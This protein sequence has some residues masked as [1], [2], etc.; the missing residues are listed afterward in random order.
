MRFKKIMLAGIILLAIM[1]IGAVGAA[2]DSDALAV[3]EDAGNGVDAPAIDEDVICDGDD[4]T[5]DVDDDDS[6]IGDEDP[7]MSV[8]FPDKVVS[9][10]KFAINVTF[11][12][13]MDDEQYSDFGFDG[14]VELFI[15]GEYEDTFSP[16]AIYNNDSTR[17][18]GFRTVVEGAVSDVGSYLFTVSFSGDETY[19]NAS[20]SKAYEITDYVIKPYIENAYY[21]E[22]TSIDFT[23]PSTYAGNI[24]VTING[25]NRTLTGDDGYSFTVDDLA[26]GVNDFGYRYADSSGNPVNVMDVINIEGKINVPNEDSCKIDSVI[27]LKMPGDANGNLSVLINVAESDEEIA[28]EAINNGYV[29]IPISRFISTLGESQEYTFRYSGDGKYSIPVEVGILSLVPNVEYPTFIVVGDGKDYYVTVTVPADNGGTVE[30]YMEPYSD[31]DDDDYDDDD[32]DDYEDD[33]DDEGDDSDVDYSNYELV[34]SAHTQNGAAKIKIPEISQFTSFLISYS[35]DDGKYNYTID[36]DIDAL[37]ADD[38]M[39]VNVDETSYIIGDMVYMDYQA[40]DFFNGTV[41]IYLDGKILNATTLIFDDGEHNLQFNTTELGCGIHTLKFVTVGNINSS[42][43]V[44]FE[45]SQCIIEF[46]GEEGRIDFSDAYYAVTV[47][48]AEGSNGTLRVTVNGKQHD[49]I[50][51]NGTSYDI[52]LSD[53]ALNRQYLVNVTYLDG[54]GHAAASKQE[55]VLFYYEIGVSFEEE[56]GT[57]RYGEENVIEIYLPDDI[58]N[59]DLIVKI[60]GEIR[61]WTADGY[62]QIYVDI[63][64]LEMGYYE[65]YV[66]YSGDE[67]Y[68]ANER[69]MEFEVVAEISGMEGYH[70]AGEEIAVVLPA[71]AEGNLVISIYESFEDEDGVVTHGD[72]PIMTKTIPL[73]NGKASYTVDDLDL[74]EYYIEAFYDGDDYDVSSCEGTYMVAPAFYFGYDEEIF[75]GEVREISIDALGETGKLTIDLYSIIETNETDEFGDPISEYVFIDSVT[76]DVNRKASWTFNP[77]KLGRVYVNATYSKNGTVIASDNWDY[78]VLPVIECDYEIVYNTTS[79]ITFKVLPSDSEGKIVLNFFDDESDGLVESYS[80][81]L[82]NGAA[83]VEIPKMKVGLYH[84]S[85]DYTGKC[86]NGTYDEYFFIVPVIN[87]PTEIKEGEDAVIEFELDGGEGNLTVTMGDKVYNATVSN[88]KAS[89]IIPKEDLSTGEKAISVEYMGNDGSRYKTSAGD[90]SSKNW[91][92]VKSTPEMTVTDNEPSTSEDVII[93]VALSDR[94][95]SGNATV[96]IDG[97]NFT[98]AFE[99]GAANVN[100][101]K[102][103]VGEYNITVTFNGNVKYV[104]VTKTASVRVYYDPK[105]VAKKATIF[106]MAGQKYSVTVYGKDG[107]I[108]KNT[109]VIFK[110][111]GKTFKKAKTNAK[112]VA[113]V[114]LTQLP[115][116]YSITA[117]AL[118]KS[119]TAKVTIKPILTLKK[120]KVKKSAKKLVIKASLK[121]VNGKYLKGKKI[122]LKFKGK[123]FTAKTNKKG[124]AKFKIGKK[125]LKKLKVGKKVKYQATYVKQTVKKSVK[126]KK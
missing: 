64:D 46:A 105:I 56:Y 88:G 126:V 124:V 96:T 94:F 42:K 72:E 22:V 111:N 95:V 31:D 81:N 44:E 2:D 98:A 104:P 14:N 87:M 100:L 123:K 110:V 60:D 125:V 89:V 40:S 80:V 15:N 109:D 21:G 4:D 106:Y 13:E 50:D 3:D 61:K 25:K 79:N 107:K 77:D 49:L 70:I 12:I 71:D 33:Y 45:V 122:T 62:G 39:Y 10:D 115:K 102:W 74:G 24:T 11:D 67:K 103:A 92:A 54:Q 36:F 53:L 85:I 73:V 43:V 97:K 9:G 29:E 108:A 48:L 99:S 51:V 6:V 5:D 27:S 37:D 35:D 55:S 91:I 116:T 84:V 75:I 82:I 57:F 30:L 1:A 28:T 59:G 118:G 121:K 52:D 69:E 16:E 68:Y 90:A 86:G 83:S 41:Y 19:A 117:Q 7:K 23:V 8:E 76:V 34:G 119:A 65:F 63:S 78:S 66:K 114:I 38:V 58:G 101:G 20:A 26:Y 93:T 113:S 112:G 120:V 17:I 32:Y 47:R 18:L